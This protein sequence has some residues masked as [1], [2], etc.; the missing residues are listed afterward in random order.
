MTTA[1]MAS[2]GVM[3][4]E[5]LVGWLVDALCWERVPAQASAVARTVHGARRLWKV[6]DLDGALAMFAGAGPAQ[7]TEDEARWAYSEWLDLVRRRFEETGVMVYSPCMGRAAA[8]VPKT[9]GTLEAV[10]V[11]GWGGSRA[12]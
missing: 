8:L 9:E 7:T 2:R 10:A 4:L 11:L 3:S 12:S 5:E 6:G 1:T